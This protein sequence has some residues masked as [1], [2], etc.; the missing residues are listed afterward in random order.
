[1]A[2]DGK[3]KKILHSRL[4][5]PGRAAKSHDVV[6]NG[7]GHQGSSTNSHT[8][9]NS[10]A[11]TNR[12]AATNPTIFTNGNITAILQLLLAFVWIQRVIYCIDMH[13]WS[14]HSAMANGDLAHVQECRVKIDVHII[15]QR[16]VVA[17]VTAKVGPHLGILTQMSKQF[18]SMTSH[19]ALVLAFIQ[20]SL[21][22]LRSVS[23]LR[24]LLIIWDVQLPS[25]HLFLFCRHCSINGC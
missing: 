15:S 20:L 5:D 17:I 3:K 1:E 19:L 2:W 24:Q 7:F 18:F 11:W 22:L 6:W 21:Q 10:D 12:D 14:K 25:K 16:D 4:D 9:A 8:V 23:F 13:A